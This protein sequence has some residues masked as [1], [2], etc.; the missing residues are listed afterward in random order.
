MAALMQSS[1]TENKILLRTYFGKGHGPGRTVTQRVQDN[2]EIL[3]FFATYL[4]LD[5]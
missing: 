3:G 2:A 5:I 4:D 1:D